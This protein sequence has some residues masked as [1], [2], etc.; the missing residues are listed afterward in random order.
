[1]VHLL[2]FAAAASKT[3]SAASTWICHT[4]AW[5]AHCITIPN[6]MVTGVTP[7]LT[8]R[9]L[10]AGPMFGPCIATV[11]ICSVRRQWSL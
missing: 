10:P 8:P 2:R 7:L 6:C 3:P 1:M 4:L 5:A 9:V 11:A